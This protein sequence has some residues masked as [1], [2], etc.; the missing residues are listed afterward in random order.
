MMPYGHGDYNCRLRFCRKGTQLDI[1][2]TRSQTQIRQQH[3]LLAFHQ[4]YEHALT[5]CLRLM[6]MMA[7]VMLAMVMLAMVIMLM[8]IKVRELMAI[9]M[10][11]IVMVS[12]I[13]TIVPEALRQVDWLC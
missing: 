8:L 11:A 2:E 7:M 5:F 4:L 6:I 3:L 12:V 1:G 9:V 13:F 10:M